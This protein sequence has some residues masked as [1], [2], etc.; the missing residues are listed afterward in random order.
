[1]PVAAFALGAVLVAITPLFGDRGLEIAAF[2]STMAGTM[3]L[4]AV[5]SQRSRAT[6]RPHR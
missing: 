5:F 4:A 3:T 1:V 2:A 6:R